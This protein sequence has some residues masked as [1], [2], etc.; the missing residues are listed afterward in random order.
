M[1]IDHINIC[2]PAEKL[3]EVRDF[4]CRALGLVEGPRPDFGIPGYW[5]Y[6]G[7]EPL[8]HLLESPGHQGSDQPYYFDHV[9]FTLTGLQEYTTRLRDMGVTYDTNHIAELDLFQVF[10]HDPCG[11]GV[12]AGF[13]GESL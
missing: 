8:V 4:Y 3:E 1:K 11:I 6:S 10:C 5:L 2:A 13:R 7:S 12:E 9:S